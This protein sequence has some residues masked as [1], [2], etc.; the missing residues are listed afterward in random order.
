MATTKPDPNK[1]TATEAQRAL[2]ERFVGIMDRCMNWP[3]DTSSMI[4]LS[5]L[6]DDVREALRK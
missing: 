1:V 4:A 3:D 6:A 5:G 2:L